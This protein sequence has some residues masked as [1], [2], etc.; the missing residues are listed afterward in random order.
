M[1]R[2]LRRFG[3]FYLQRGDSLGI[4]FAVAFML[5]FLL[6]MAWYGR[7]IGSR[8]ADGDPSCAFGPKGTTCSL[9]SYPPRQAVAPIGAPLMLRCVRFVALR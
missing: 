6:F 7:L 3:W 9:T 4:A 1:R 8:I 2:H 5:F